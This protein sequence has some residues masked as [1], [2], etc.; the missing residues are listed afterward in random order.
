MKLEQTAIHEA[1]HVVV[2]HLLGLACNEVALTRDETEET[3]EYGHVCHPHPAFGYKCSSLRE[4]QGILRDQSIADCAGLAAE[5]VFFGV[6]L[7]AENENSQF[8][9][10]NVIQYEREGLRM[11]RGRGGYIGDDAT[12]RYISRQLAKAKKLV[13][14][15]RD[16]I[17]RFADT[18]V[19]RKKLSSEEVKELLNELMPSEK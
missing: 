14:D 15:H 2:A 12:W 3:D 9:F 13:K 10:Q 1:G 19:E 17:Q 4:R 6:P 18:L 8:D 7:D 5:H 11:R 16:T